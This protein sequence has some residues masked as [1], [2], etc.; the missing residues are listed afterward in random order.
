MKT[1]WSVELASALLI[2]LFAYAG[3]SKASEL[4]QV[5]ISFRQSFGSVLYHAGWSYALVIAEL[6]TAGLLLFPRA[7]AAGFFLSFSLMTAFLLYTLYGWINPHG[8]PC[9]CGGVISSLSWPA[10]TFFNLFFWA[11]SVY[12]LLCSVRT[13]KRKFN[14]LL[15]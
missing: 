3:L 14:A 4:R 11:I 15:Q 2:L 13:F 5:I 12:G 7:R 1:S 9:S 8:M 6:L 10:H